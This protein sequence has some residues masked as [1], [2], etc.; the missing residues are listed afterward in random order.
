M[1]SHCCLSLLPPTAAAHHRPPLPPPQAKEERDLVLAEQ[2]FQGLGWR[3]EGGDGSVATDELLA[4]L[5]KRA[6]AYKEAYEKAR[7]KEGGAGAVT[8]AW[9]MPPW[10]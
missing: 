3:D 6:V 5:L 4:A 1:R 10:R 2:H 8:V 7:D 9:D